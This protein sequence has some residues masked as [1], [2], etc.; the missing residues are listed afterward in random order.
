[1]TRER[2]D[3]HFHLLPGLDD[4]PATIDESLDLARAAVSDGTSTVAATPH[5][6][7]DFVTDVPGLRDHVRELKEALAR[8]DVPLA[9]SPGGELGHDMV[10]R[11][12][13]EELDAIAQGPPRRRW[14]LVETPFGGLTE[15]FTA[16]TDE[17]RDRGFGVVLAH[18]ERSAGLLNGRRALLDHELAAGSLLQ[19]NAGSPAG[20]HGAD[21]RAVALEL[22]WRGL[23]TAV[24]S[25]AH[26]L[27]R[28]PAL[29]LAHDVLTAAGVGPARVRE[30]IDSAPRRLLARG[31]ETPRLRERHASLP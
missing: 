28:A 22:V 27:H 10:G 19:V 26:G 7:G 21:A 11:L 14:L 5:V 17:L 15:D 1:M 4:G 24:A 6:R 31:L 13:Q 18:P 20:H 8:A 12:R 16:A 30:L 3:I 25:D 9:V 2:A 29:T 23:A